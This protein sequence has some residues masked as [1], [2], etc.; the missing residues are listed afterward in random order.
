M[1][2]RFEAEELDAET[3]EYLRTAAESEGHG[4]PGV[5]FGGKKASLSTPTLLIWAAVCGPLLVLL[6][7]G[8]TW[9]S[10]ADPINT[11]MFQT[12]GFLL[13]GWLFLAWVRSWLDRRR[14]DY[15]GFFKY[16]D[17]LYLWV[18]TGRGVEVRGMEMV[19]SA[20]TEHHYDGNG[21]Y[22]YT[23]VKVKLADG[24]E[25]LD[26][27]SHS[28]AERL[29]EFLTALAEH[30]GGEP[31]ARGYAAVTQV[32]AEDSEDDSDPAERAV[33]AI[34]RPR[35]ERSSAAWVGLV[36][37]PVLGV[38][39]FLAC[40]AFATAQRDEAYFEMVKGGPADQLRAYLADRRNGR[41]RD[42][43]QRR[44]RAL[45][46]P[47]A[48]RLQQQGDPEVAAGLAD[49]VRAVAGDPRPVVTLCVLKP[50]APEDK[51]SPAL[52]ETMNRQIIKEISDRLSQ[53]VGQQVA[54]YAETTEPPAQVEFRPKVTAR[55]GEDV[56]I[57]WDVVLQAG[58]EAKRHTLTLLTTE[59]AGGEN[60]WPAARAAYLKLGQA[61]NARLAQPRAAK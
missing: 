8:L 50:D 58:P 32:K 23:T 53:H 14:S 12:A 24:K 61:F 44:L 27:R 47:T 11:A 1:Y 3:R 60:P 4:M 42:E 21:N 39:L 9:G 51:L 15:L 34:P 29:V 19:Q 22:K 41:H 28:R 55:P 35:R 49:I 26:V 59:K 7:L 46:E 37:L 56:R 30:P 33:T 36:L 48:V 17:P 54:D 52:V 6:T 2:Q 31:A 45:A 43:V 18:G 38:A 20:Y 40:K 10:L 25:E 5:F 13:G 16:V 57:D